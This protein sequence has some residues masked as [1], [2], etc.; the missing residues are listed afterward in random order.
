MFYSIMLNSPTHE[1]GDGIRNA[2]GEYYGC[3][4]HYK[5]EV[6]DLEDGSFQHALIQSKH[7]YHWLNGLIGSLCLLR[8][9]KRGKNGRME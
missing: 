4:C 7:I 8:C 5:L 9:K 1:D 2:V 6:D 3:C